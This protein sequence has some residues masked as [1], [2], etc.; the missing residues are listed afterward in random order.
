MKTA[1]I[2]FNLGGPDTSTAVRPFLFNL[3]S[4]PAIFRLPFFLRIPLAWMVSKLR[5]KKAQPIYDQLGG[6]SPILPNTQAQADGLQKV[7]GD[8]FKVFIAMRY[9]QPRAF[10]T[11]QAVRQYN[12]T[13]IVLLP[14]YPQYST[15]T[16]ASSIAEW[17][18][19]A[20]L[21]GLDKVTTKT[22]CCY[23]NSYGFIQGQI[24][25]IRD[26]VHKAWQ[27][28]KPRLLFSAHGLPEKV[29]KDGDPYQW[30]CEQTAQ[31]LAIA[32]A[33]D[34]FD[35]VNTYQSRVGP[36]KWIGPSTEEEIVAAGVSG[37]PVVIVP[38]SFVSEHS[39]TLVELDI[40]Y[41]HLA[42]E[43]GVPYYGR[44]PTVSTDAAFISGLAELVQRTL[45]DER[46][47]CS[48]DG[49]R[50]C[51]AHFTGCPMGKVA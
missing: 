14:L 13:R 39:E 31:A 27:Y 22:L 11:V 37:T 1:V 42:Y 15:T 48:Q 46:R 33:G 9:W 36:L 40:E 28:G 49:H 25:A 41:K 16:S 29:V 12:P 21:A 32:L 8:T 43:K 30:Q 6:G 45:K 20:K 4:D 23:P 10:E 44:V 17:H 26:E 18:K 34:E 50:I 35:W 7:L 3:F 38:M 19:V 24:K 5:E 47:V 2:L 51:P